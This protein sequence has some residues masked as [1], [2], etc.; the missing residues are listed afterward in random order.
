MFPI[1]YGTAWYGV[2]SNE[3]GNEKIGEDVVIK[4]NSYWIIF[5]F[6]LV[7]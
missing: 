7:R 6:N 4:P 2:N 1:K 5:K 3:E